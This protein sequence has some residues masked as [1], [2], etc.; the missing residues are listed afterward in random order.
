MAQ[1]FGGRYSPGDQVRRDTLAQPTPAGPPSIYD[2]RRPA[3]AGARSNLLFLIALLPAIRGFASG[4]AGLAFGIGATALMLSAAALTREGL[5]AEAAYEAR[6][7]AK[8]PAIPRKIFGAVLTGAGLAMAGMMRSG[9]LSVS[10]LFGLIGT[11]LHIGA[12]GLDPLRDKG[13]EGIDSFQSERVARAVDEAE[14]HLAAMKDAILRAHDRALEA[15]VDRFTEAARA[16][17]RRVEEDPGDLTAARK[18]LGV[19]LMGARDAT[20]KFADLYAA[21]RDPKARTDYEAL[22]DDLQTTFAN[23][24][25]QLLGNDSDA[26]DVEI[27]V[28]RERLQYEEPRR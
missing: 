26:L 10:V 21:S 14:A 7:V 23:R 12:F 1:R 24:S 20:V 8:R 27:Q 18:Y 19:Y 16:L 13:G 2:S 17:F 6:K 15:R 11:A 5:R 22:L 28:L 4:P 9:S 25:Q 3:K